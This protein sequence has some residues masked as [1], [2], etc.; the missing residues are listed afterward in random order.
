MIQ[1]LLF[2]LGGVIMEIE[3]QRCVNAYERL[4][5]S[6]ADSFLGEYA[7]QGAFADLESGSITPALFRD[8]I[9]NKIGNP[10]SD[11]E[12]DNAFEQFL[13]GIPVHR[14]RA[15]EKLHRNYGIYMLSNTNAIMWNGKIA[16][17]FRKDGHHIDHYFDGIVTSF[18]AKCM[19]PSAEIFDYAAHN[20]G[21][22][23]T[24]TLF[25][26]DSEANCQSARALG[27]NAQVVTPGTEFADILR[28]KYSIE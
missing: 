24:T 19:K 1:N 12:I 17:E 15:L 7:Q 2:D 27:W 5:F 9:R 23:P 6:D 3:R 8:F 21:L 11:A 14:L 26:D 20:L 4:G 16:A 28:Q 10:V 25:L 13:I 22:D 18:T